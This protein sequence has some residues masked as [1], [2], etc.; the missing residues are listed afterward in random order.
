MSDRAAFLNHIAAHPDA[1][2]PR[3][4]FA[5]WLD[6]QGDPLGEFIRVQIE[7]SYRQDKL[8][9]EETQ[10][11]LAREEELLELH[12]QRWMGT[13][14]EPFPGGFDF[15]FVRGLPLTARLHWVHFIQ[16]AESIIDRWP[17][18]STVALGFA[19]GPHNLSQPT[20]LSRFAAI[21]FFGWPQT[22]ELDEL[23]RSPS[24]DPGATLRLNTTLEGRTNFLPDIRDHLDRIGRLELVQPYPGPPVGRN[25]RLIDETIEELVADLNRSAGR[26]LAVLLRPY[27]RRYPLLGDLGGGFYAGHLKSGAAALFG[28]APQGRR[29]AFCTFTDAGRVDKSLWEDT[30]SPP[31]TLDRLRD[32]FGF[33][34]GFIRVREFEAN[35]RLAIRFWP[36]A[37]R[38]IIA[39]GTYED[40]PEF[41][42]HLADP[43]TFAVG[44]GEREVRVAYRTGRGTGAVG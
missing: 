44:F 12:R 20:A 8:G 24:W 33:E 31:W 38:A 11:L 34:L 37:A 41:A 30:S 29:V 23:L 27:E 19:L 32:R 2:L 28:I 17:T 40:D 18:I 3:L 22:Y 5:D 10:A 14:G 26:E 13:F 1:D 35:N 42:D 15:Q 43:L 7:L 21:H 39:D 9:D 16:F 36:R 25:P 4:V 6:E